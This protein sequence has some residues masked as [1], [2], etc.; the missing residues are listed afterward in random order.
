MTRRS[1]YFCM[2]LWLGV[3]DL[4][5]TLNVSRH[6]LLDALCLLSFIHD[7]AL[8]ALFF[9]VF[10]RSSV[11]ELSLSFVRVDLNNDSCIVK[12]SPCV[13][14][15]LVLSVSQFLCGEIWR[16]RQ[17]SLSRIGYG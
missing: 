9:F 1:L 16:P 15:T 6:V 7:L 14:L 5:C 2:F 10:Y 13:G 11:L 12:S 17:D 3:S 8:L 4:S